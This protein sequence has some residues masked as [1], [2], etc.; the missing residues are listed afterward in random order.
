MKI[1]SIDVFEVPT[2]FATAINKFSPIVVRI[3]TDEGIS[4]FG[5]VG[6]AYGLGGSAGFG[7]AKDLAKLLIGMDPMKNELI[8][9]TM[10]KKTFWGQG[11]G[12]VVSAGMSGIDI[13]L[14]DIKGKAYNMP[15]YQLLGGK[16]RDKIRA[17]ASQLQFGWGLGKDKQM[18]TEPSQYA[19][20]A[21]AAVAEGYDAIKVDAIAMDMQGN[22]NKHKLNGVLSDQVVRVGYNRLKAIRKAVG[23]D[24]D[25]I[26]ENHAL[27]DT[28]A[29]IQYGRMIEE[30]KIHYYEEPVMPLNPKQMK[31]VADNV[32]I[33]IAAGERIYTRWGYRPFLEDGSIA[34]IQ[35]DICT[36]GGLTEAK[37][38]CDM[39]HIYDVTVQVHVCGGPI[40]NAAALHVEAA[41]PNFE[42]HEEHRF[43]AIESNINK[44]KYQY[45]P[46]NGS[47]EVPD[48]PGIGQELTEEA[49]KESIMVTVK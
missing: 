32:K 24:V 2:E 35:P 12:T 4:G 14:W 43:F 1:T 5:E 46:K 42:I 26:V 13:A 22:W 30:L 20:A 17:Y 3:N 49:I 45:L 38:I 29:A 18:L 36:C 23:P 19:E 15:V 41:I 28:T 40:S 10:Q 44:C 25:I 16:T 8:W 47:Y 11:G 34:V 7:M 9:N 37:K 48:L 33:P 39:A 21:M 27:T 31:K 6:M